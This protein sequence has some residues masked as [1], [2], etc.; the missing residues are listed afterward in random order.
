MR[1]VYGEDK[2]AG[3]GQMSPPKQHKRGERGAKSLENRKQ[4]EKNKTRR[5]TCQFSR[6][7]PVKI[8]IKKGKI[9]LSQIVQNFRN[10]SPADP[11]FGKGRAL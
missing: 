1:P 7:Y 2:A 4:K 10:G 3:S 6:L 8:S 5:E 9:E 11:Q